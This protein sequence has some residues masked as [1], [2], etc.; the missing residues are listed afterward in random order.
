[1]DFAVQFCEQIEVETEKLR[2]GLVTAK[3]DQQQ[4]RSSPSGV[5]TASGLFDCE[6]AGMQCSPSCDNLRAPQFIVTINE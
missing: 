1:M 2:D 4:K 5:V 6:Y 3:A